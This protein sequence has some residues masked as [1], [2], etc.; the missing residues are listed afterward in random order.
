MI[1]I[2]VTRH[3]L[4]EQI[5]REL[6]PFGRVVFRIAAGDLYGI[7]VQREAQREVYR[8]WAVARQRRIDRIDQLEVFS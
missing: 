8:R 1:Y 7:W 4:R 6:S 2:G 3:H 5:Y